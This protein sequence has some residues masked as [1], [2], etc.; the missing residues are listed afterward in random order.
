MRKKAIIS[1]F[2]VFQIF[3]LYLLL[4]VQVTDTEILSGKI[5]EEQNAIEV[6]FYVLWADIPI[7]L[8]ARKWF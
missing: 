4:L 2:L 8:F 5:S 6:S 1:E 7:Q 3:Y